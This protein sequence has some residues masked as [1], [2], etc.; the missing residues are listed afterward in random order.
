M[1]LLWY[2]LQ[3]IFWNESG[4]YH[5][6]V[7]YGNYNT[8]VTVDTS[9]FSKYALE[10]PICDTHHLITLKDHMFIGEYL[11]MLVFDTCQAYEIRHSFKRYRKRWVMTRLGY[12]KMIVVKCQVV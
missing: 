6:H 11:H 7:F 3:S 8:I 12:L 1:P 2:F 5:T 10:F 4:G 9:N